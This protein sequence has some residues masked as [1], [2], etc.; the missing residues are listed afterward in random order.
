MQSEI[1]GVITSL[2]TLMNILGPLWAGLVYDHIMP[3]APYWM[4][5]ILLIIA[6]IIMSRVKTGNNTT[7]PKT[8]Y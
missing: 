6:F 1:F 3:S 8:V 5:A 2:F 4:G 7:S